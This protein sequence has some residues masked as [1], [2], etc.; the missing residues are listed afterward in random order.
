MKAA[1]ALICLAASAKSQPAMAP[2]QIGFIQD[3]T[4]ALRPAYGV[5]GSF[6]IGNALAKG[7]VNE[8][9]S[10]QVGLLK[11]D[12]SLAAFDS[13]GKVLGTRNA[14]PGPALFA[15]SP[16][17]SA[18][19][20]YVPAKN[21]LLEWQGTSFA[22]ILLERD[23]I[24]RGSVLAIAFCSPWE[25]AFILESQ[26]GIR[27][28]HLPLGPGGTFS[29]NALEGVR[30]PLLV[31]PSGELL[32]REEGGIVIRKKD[33]SEIH[34]AASLPARFSLRQ[35]N[36]DW[37][38]VVEPSGA[39]LAIRTTDGREQLFRLPDSR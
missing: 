17:G 1:I 2:P 37:V 36:R 12:S 29:R 30:A 7:I 28:I 5:A 39:A 15:F 34:I 10:G 38:Q 27:E 20:A 9:F 22:P 21:S 14:L 32:Y 25:A 11:T 24:G 18:G 6:V 33:A 3:G 13:T 31:L 19:L 16:N 35:M 4:R 26:G 23:E 8:A